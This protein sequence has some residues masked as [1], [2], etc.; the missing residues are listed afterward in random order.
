MQ[1]RITKLLILLFVAT[2]VLG[3]IFWSQFKK[4]RGIV[5]QT[6]QEP[7]VSEQTYNIPVDQSEPLLGNPG[8]LLT[9]IL[10]IDLGDAKSRALANTLITFTNNHPL[11]IRL[12]WKDA[13][14]RHF[15]SLDPLPAHR[16]AWCANDQHRFWQFTESLLAAGRFDEKQLT[17]S[18]TDAKLDLA[19]WNS[20]RTATQADTHLSAAHDEARSL[21][22]TSFPAL[23]LNNKKINTSEDVDLNQMLTS[24]IAK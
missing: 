5:T 8:A 15:L 2:L 3:F 1:S 22:L 4:T 11:D 18:A 23:F 14:Q 12:T 17:A 16:A 13:P 19:E 24:F 7:L 6:V 10:Y 9:A 21:G 20:C